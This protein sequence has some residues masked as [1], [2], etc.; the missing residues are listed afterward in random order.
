MP[1]L[2]HR[3]I[4]G[5]PILTFARFLQR[6]GIDA[7]HADENAIDAGAA[8]LLDEAADLVRHR[9]DLRDDLD[10]QAFLFAHLDQPVED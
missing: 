1:R 4:L 2:Q 6:F 9:V 7:F 8:R 5:N 10:R 3:S